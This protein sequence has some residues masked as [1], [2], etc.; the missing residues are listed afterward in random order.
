MYTMSCLSSRIKID[1]MHSNISAQDD[2][3]RHVFRNLCVLSCIQKLVLD[4]YSHICV[5]GGPTWD[6]LVQAT[7]V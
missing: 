3:L 6:E 4:M 7:I 5:W 2:P 1:D